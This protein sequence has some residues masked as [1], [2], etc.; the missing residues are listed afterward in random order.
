VVCFLIC[1]AVSVDVDVDNLV[2]DVLEILF[3]DSVLTS[4]TSTTIV[5]LRIHLWELIARESPKLYPY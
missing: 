3:S 4:A 2:F 1:E 5:L